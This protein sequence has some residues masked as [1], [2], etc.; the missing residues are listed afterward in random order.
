MRGYAN[1]FYDVAE[2]AA[3]DLDK[4]DVIQ[5]W[6]AES[7]LLS[8]VA[9]LEEDEI[10]EGDDEQVTNLG[11]KIQ[12][13]RAAWSSATAKVVL[14]IVK[15]AMESAVRL[16]RCVSGEGASV[17]SDL[18]GMLSTFRTSLN[19][20]ADDPKG[21]VTAAATAVGRPITPAALK[22]LAE[23]VEAAAKAAVLKYDKHVPPAMAKLQRRFRFDPRNT[24]E[25]APTLAS[26]KNFF[27]CL[28]SLVGN[29]LLNEYKD[30]VKEHAKL[31]RKVVRRALPSVVEGH[32]AEMEDVEVVD[33]IPAAFWASKRK[34]WPRLA[35]IAR[36]WQ[37]F[38][39]SSIAVERVFGM[40]RTMETALMNRRSNE[41]F[42]D[43]LIFRCNGWVLD[44]LMT[45]KQASIQAVYGSALCMSLDRGGA[46]S[47]GQGLG[48][49]FQ[50]AFPVAA[51]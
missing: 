25:D 49:A 22:A 40:M 6:V 38:P 33:V 20:F 43:E 1:R 27:G 12:K 35:V 3:Y 16:V 45:Q 32:A 34:V 28:P 15:D 37:E 30:Y 7:P 39:T 11:T 2:V 9:D 17:P 19:S 41:T 47:S 8:S 10:I 5:K 24:P 26:M 13:V 31:P 21:S 46:S 14:Q 48:P 50:A 36:Y 44:N 42:T 18:T 4:F 29:P 23:Q 51:G